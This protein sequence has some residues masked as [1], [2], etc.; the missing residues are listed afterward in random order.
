MMKPGH[1]PESSAR[2]MSSERLKESKRMTDS[3]SIISA[4]S[5]EMAVERPVGSQEKQVKSPVCLKRTP[6]EDLADNGV[7]VHMFVGRFRERGTLHK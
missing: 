5:E 7:V 4:H 2:N 1:G 3:K 6:Q